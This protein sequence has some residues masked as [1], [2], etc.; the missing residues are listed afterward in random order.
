MFPRP[1]LIALLV[2]AGPLLVFEAYG[3]HQLKKSL[4]PSPEGPLDIV[5]AQLLQSAQ[6]K[7][8]TGVAREIER[9]SGPEPEAFFDSLAPFLNARLERG[10]KH[11]L[12]SDEVRKKT[13]AE[14]GRLMKRQDWVAS[15]GNL[16][17]TT[18]DVLLLAEWNKLPND[19]VGLTLRA[20]QLG[21][22]GEGVQATT[23]FVPPSAVQRLE[24][25]RDH[26]RR[27]LYGAAVPLVML[28]FFSVGNFVFRRLT[29][30]M[31]HGPTS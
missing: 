9:V 7:G 26:L 8:L 5:C 27:M 4:P 18:P 30:G 3:I 22:S 12:F 2:L 25:K 19:E 6:A 23:R 1:V 13:V 29:G 17:Q 14:I 11:F 21:V 15:P 10:F 28:A 20:V 24:Q 16:T 31:S